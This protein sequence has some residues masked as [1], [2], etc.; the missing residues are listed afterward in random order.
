[1][2]F[3][4][5]KDNRVFKPVKVILDFNS[6]EEVIYFLKTISTNYTRI[7]NNILDFKNYSHCSFDNQEKMYNSLKTRLINELEDMG[8]NK[9]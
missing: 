5:H 7:K 6:P 4:V 3:E 2:K 8:I 1:M 9:L